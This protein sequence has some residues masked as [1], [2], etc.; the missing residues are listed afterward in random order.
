VV[1]FEID[2][3]PIASSDLRERARRGEPLDGLVPAAVAD[4]VARRGLYRSA[5]YTDA[6]RRGDLTD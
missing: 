4:E 5:R 3:P 6:D 1:F 2:A